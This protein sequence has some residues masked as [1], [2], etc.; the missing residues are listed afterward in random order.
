MRENDF[1]QFTGLSGIHEQ[2]Q[3]GNQEAKVSGAQVSPR[4]HSQ[5][6]SQ[7]SLAHNYA[8]YIDWCLAYDF[9]FNNYWNKA[10]IGRIL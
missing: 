2:S 8:W 5:S 9:A 4:G 7:E 3:G 6:T 10:V 1:F